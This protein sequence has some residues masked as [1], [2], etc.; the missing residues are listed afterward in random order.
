MPPKQ[1]AGS[2]ARASRDID[3]AREWVRGFVRWYNTEHLH[4]ALNFVTPDDR[5]CGH[6]KANERREPEQDLRAVSRTRASRCS[7]PESRPCR[8]RKVDVE[9]GCAIQDVDVPNAEDAAFDA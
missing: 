9:H 3:E 1:R 2:A 7:P 4:S 8:E 5:Y 6:D